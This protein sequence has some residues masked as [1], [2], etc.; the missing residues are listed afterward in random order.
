MDFKNVF[1]MLPCYALSRAEKNII[2][3]K[4]KHLFFGQRTVYDEA[5][6]P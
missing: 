3:S 6:S 5:N 1:F 4:I 2:K